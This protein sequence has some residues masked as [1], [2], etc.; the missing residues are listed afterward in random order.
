MQP[1]LEHVAV[2]QD[3]DR[4]DET[5]PK[6]LAEHLLVPGVV[7]MRRMARTLSVLYV[8]SVQSMLGY[9]VLECLA[10]RRFHC[11]MIVARPLHLMLHRRVVMVVVIHVSHI[12]PLVYQIQ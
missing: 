5:D 9:S 3:R 6:A 10:V 1:H 8:G 4:E 2:E 12:S 7:N 11:A